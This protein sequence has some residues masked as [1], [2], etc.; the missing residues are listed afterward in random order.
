MSRRQ[1]VT[2][3]EVRQALALRPSR[4]PVKLSFDQAAWLLEYM[5]TS[6]PCPALLR[7]SLHVP[8]GQ[9][10][11]AQRLRVKAEVA[12]AH[13]RVGELLAGAAV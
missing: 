9:V 4:G 13:E 11:P 8:P 6:I 1:P 10:G 12:A 3:Y 5:D 2:E 7:P